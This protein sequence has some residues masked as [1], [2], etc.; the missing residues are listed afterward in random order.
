MKNAFIW[1]MGIV[2]FLAFIGGC[3]SE[4]TETVKEEPKQEVKA[5][6]PKE[7][8]KPEKKPEKAPE[9]AIDPQAALKILQ[10]SYKG[11]AEVKFIEETDTFTVLPIDEGITIEMAKILDGQIDIAIW[12]ELVDSFAGVSKSLGPKY[13]LVMLNPANPDNYILMAGNGIVMYDAI[14]EEKG[15][16]D[17]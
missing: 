8:K 17:L 6:Q 4:D 12:N 5:E 2:A 9:D 15:G 16:E 3:F 1:F 10:D 7:D 11:T 14:T 13:L